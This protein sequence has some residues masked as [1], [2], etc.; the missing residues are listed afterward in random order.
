MAALIQANDKAIKHYYEQLSA[1]AGQNALHESN[2]RRAFQTLL[3]ETTRVKNW[4]LGHFVFLL[5]S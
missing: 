3:S 2:V 5:L 4:A 1:A